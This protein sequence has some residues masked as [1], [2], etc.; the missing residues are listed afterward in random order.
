MKCKFTCFL[1]Y[2]LLAT[3]TALAD[4][5]FQISKSSAQK[6]FMKFSSV[7]QSW[8]FAGDV[9]FS[10]LS[11]PVFM[12]FQPRR[13][14][15]VS[16]LASQSSVRGDGLQ[17][18]KGFSDTQVQ[19]N[20]RP[21]G[22]NLVFHLGFNLPSGKKQL[23]EEEFAT[24]LVL[25]QNVFDFQIPNLGQGFNLSAGLS[26]TTRLNDQLVVGL[27]ASYQYRGPYRA[28]NDLLDDYK[29][30]T[31]LL[32]TGGLDIRL[33]NTT[34]FNTDII[35]THFGTDQIGSDQVFAPGNRVVFN[36]QFRKYF[37][38]NELWL[39]VR[40]RNRSKNQRAVQIGGDLL[41]EDQKTYPSHFEFKGHYRVRMKRSFYV[42]FVLDGRFYQETSTD[43][44]GINLFGV[45]LAPEFSLSRN[46]ILPVTL[47][48]F[49]G[50]DKNGEN[51]SG[52]QFGLGLGYFF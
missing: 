51:I 36:A 3:T 8:T 48:Y 31:E 49:T 21:R 50:G 15:S 46:L 25:S 35:F 2:L 32:F 43:F 18:L 33:N 1:V 47:K 44:S 23:T 30:G 26:W 13:D 12:I 4:D 5:I 45:G 10:E 39:F 22:Y 40:Y 34:S 7:Y 6:N 11:F 17:T 27:G 42:K 41:T 38:F 19:L 14:L 37:N 29:P 20:Y 9:D 16:L 52:F 24:S 28:L